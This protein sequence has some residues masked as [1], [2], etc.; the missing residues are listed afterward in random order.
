MFYRC[1]YCNHFIGEIHEIFVHIL[2]KQCPKKDN[3]IYE[4]DGLPNLEYSIIEKK[5][6]IYNNI[7]Y[8]NE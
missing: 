1:N 3:F 6:N 5:N 2:K 7:L 4:Y 8:A